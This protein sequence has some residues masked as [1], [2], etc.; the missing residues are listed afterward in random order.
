MN[1]C[2]VLPTNSKAFTLHYFC[3]LAYLVSTGVLGLN[4]VHVKTCRSKYQNDNN[5]FIIF[6]AAINVSKMPSLNNYDIFSES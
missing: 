1:P 6:Y 4:S 2:N 3:A 5:N